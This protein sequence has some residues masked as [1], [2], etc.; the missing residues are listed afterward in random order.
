[1]MRSLLLLL[2]P[3]FLLSSS[4]PS[5]PSKP[6]QWDTDK[7]PNKPA[8]YRTTDPY[9]I[10]P[11]GSLIDWRPMRVASLAHVTVDFGKEDGRPIQ[12]PKEYDEP[13]T[14]IEYGRTCVMTLGFTARESR[15]ILAFL[16]TAI[17]P[18]IETST[19][20]FYRLTRRPRR[21]PYWGRLPDMAVFYSKDKKPFINCNLHKNAQHIQYSSKAEFYFVVCY[22][23]LEDLMT[24]KTRANIKQAGD[25][26]YANFVNST[27]GNQHKMGL[28]WN[29]KMLDL[30]FLE[31]SRIQK[32]F[33]HAMKHLKGTGLNTKPFE[34]WSETVMPHYDLRTVIYE[35]RYKKV[36]TEA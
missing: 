11:V 12:M 33:K 24:N 36:R 7:D 14:S 15:P 2:L 20:G 1:R 4:P 19:V 10:C 31:P 28:K 18:L 35:T 17:P 29:S 23:K 22:G 8:R 32:R 21:S 25:E 27:T 13:F 16:G 5:P 9:T 26:I 34:G 6:Y 3:S 30:S